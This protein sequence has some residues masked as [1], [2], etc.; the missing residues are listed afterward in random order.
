MVQGQAR[1]EEFISVHGLALYATGA[2]ALKNLYEETKFNY[3]THDCTSN[4]GA[5][6]TEAGRPSLKGFKV[7]LV[8]IFQRV[9]LTE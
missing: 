4:L 6:R 9:C 7:S 5:F 8:K 1:Q 2:D 3:D